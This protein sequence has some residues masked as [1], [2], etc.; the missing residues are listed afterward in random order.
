[1]P[2]QRRDQTP[3]SPPSFTDGDEVGG[4]GGGDPTDLNDARTPFALFVRELAVRASQR[5]DGYGAAA[6]AADMGAYTRVY[7]ELVCEWRHRGLWNDRWGAVPGHLWRG[8]ELRGFLSMGTDRHPPL[9]LDSDP[10][11]EGLDEFVSRTARVVTAAWLG[12]NGRDGGGG[13]DGAGAT[14]TDDHDHDDELSPPPPPPPPGPNNPRT[15]PA[16][17]AAPPIAIVTLPPYD[18]AAA[19]ARERSVGGTVTLSVGRL[20]VDGA[21]E[22]PFSYLRDGHG[23]AAV[24]RRRGE[25]LRRLQHLGAAPR[26]E[27]NAAGG[28]SSSSSSRAEVQQG[29]KRELDDDDEAAD[30]GEAAARGPK[31]QAT[32]RGRGDGGRDGD[33]K[34]EQ[35]SPAEW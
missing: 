6:A 17:A 27:D 28:S 1:M 26:E 13:G 35:V 11:I 3:P 14:R 29:I 21:L 24:R 8:K 16:G 4:G 19:K 34:E 2:K 33:A 5:L 7:H 23:V 32:E 12:N 15:R 20:D 10:V 30:A 31:R 22:S 18:P 25:Q 9:G